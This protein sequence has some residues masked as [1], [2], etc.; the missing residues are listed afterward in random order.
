MF[1]ASMLV[2]VADS[3]YAAYACINFYLVVANYTDVF[4]TLVRKKFRLRVRFREEQAR[5][6]PR[7]PRSVS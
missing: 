5:W 3:S 4:Y 6:A 1:V 7:S 2:G